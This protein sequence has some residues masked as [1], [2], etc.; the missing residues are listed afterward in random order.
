MILLTSAISSLGLIASHGMDISASYEIHNLTA[1]LTVISSN[2]II[3]ANAGLAFESSSVLNRVTLSTTYYTG[4]CPGL[5]RNWMIGRF[6]SEV[7]RPSRNL[8]V[9]LTNLSGQGEAPYTDREYS[10]G[11]S[12]E[13]TRVSIGSSHE[14]Q[15][16]IVTPGPNKI[17]YKISGPS[18]SVETGNF[19]LYVDF[20]KVEQFRAATTKSERLCAAFASLPL[21]QCA[22]IRLKQSRVCPDGKVLSS[23]IQPDTPMIRTSIVNQLATQQS[24]LFNGMPISLYPGQE[25]SFYLPKYGNQQIVYDGYPYN[26]TIG[27]RHRITPGYTGAVSIY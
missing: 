23:S 3:Q 13:S 21:D 7:T 12:S 22:D 11:A 9:R 18:E 15:Y 10:D 5:A 26:L 4:D 2:A 16:F 17:A 19:E 25:F 1:P 8:R 27:K 6:R 14:K 20:N 24:F